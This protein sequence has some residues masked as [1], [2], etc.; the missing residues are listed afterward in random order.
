MVVQQ[1][2]RRCS[3][4]LEKHPIRTEYLCQVS[5]DASAVIFRFH[6][7]VSCNFS[8]DQ[9]LMMY[10]DGVRAAKFRSL[11]QSI[12]RVIWG[13]LHFSLW[14]VRKLGKNVTTDGVRTPRKASKIVHY[15]SL[16]LGLCSRVP[17]FIKPLL[18]FS[19]RYS[20]PEHH[21]TTSAVYYQIPRL[22]RHYNMRVT[23]TV[24][25]ASTQGGMV[26]MTHLM[27]RIQIRAM[28]I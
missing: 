14:L 10:L 24:Q 26:E 23:M 28:M 7:V 13:W 3:I 15:A 20:V 16:L 2:G 4:V 9:Q 8:T 19:Y 12:K 21:C 5:L 18:I 22:R 17:P 6:I 27:I 11:F 1:S 25:M